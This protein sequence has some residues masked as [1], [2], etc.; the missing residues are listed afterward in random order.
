M[1]NT[2]EISKIVVNGIMY[3][4]KDTTARELIAGGVTFIISTDASN[5]PEGVTWETPEGVTIVGTLAAASAKKGGIYL[6]LISGAATKAVYAEYIAVNKGTEADPSYFWERLGD[7]ETTLKGLVTEVVFNKGSG[8]LVLGEGTTFTASQSS[9]SFSGGSDD[10]FVKSYPGVTSKLVK[11][12]ITGVDGSQSV[13]GIAS[14]TGVTASKA[15]AAADLEASIVTTASKE[16][17]KVV[18]GTDTTASKATAGTAYSAAGVGIDVSVNG[19]TSAISD[20]VDAEAGHGLVYNMRVSNETLSFDTVGTTVKTATKAGADVS[21]TPYSFTN[22]TV[23]VVSSHEDV[24]FKAVDT[25]ESVTIKQHTFADVEASKVVSATAFNA[26]KPAASATSVATGTLAVDGTGDSIL[27]ALGKAVTADA[28]TNI[29]TGVAAAQT[30]TVGTND[31]VKVAKYD[32]L[33]ISVT[34]HD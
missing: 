26:A 6:V 7:T 16:A 34:K 24:S 32:D 9:V 19:V 4:L 11:T 3:D 8:D 25:N 15:T 18:F 12:S 10:T 22:V 21:I 5:T 13:T 31:K 23:P 27:T 14:N 20:T 1:A 33:S 29:G 28:I 2:N 30:I 17:T